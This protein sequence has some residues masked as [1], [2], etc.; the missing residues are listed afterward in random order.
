[1]HVALRQ[2]IPSIALTIRYVRKKKCTWSERF[3]HIERHY[4]QETNVEMGIE[5][6]IVK[7]HFRKREANKNSRHPTNLLMKEIKME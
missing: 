1:M 4:N 3:F 6:K 7:K 5:P 2:L